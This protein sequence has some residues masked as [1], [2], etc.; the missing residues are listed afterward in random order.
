[1]KPIT[2]ITIISTNMPIVAASY[3]D[4]TGSVV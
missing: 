2:P 3:R 1:M 4:A